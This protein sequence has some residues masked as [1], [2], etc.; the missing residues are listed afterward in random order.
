[1]LIICDDKFGGLYFIPWSGSGSCGKAV[2]QYLVEKSKKWFHACSN[3]LRDPGDI[4]ECIKRFN[5][6]G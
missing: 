4:A 5:G 1:M 2:P 3:V 6:L